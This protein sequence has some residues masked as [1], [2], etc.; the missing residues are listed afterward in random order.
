M[1]NGLLKKMAMMLAKVPK[2]DLEKNIEVAKNILS[3]SNKDDLNKFINSKE[4]ENLL[5]KEKKQISEALKNNEI[6]PE[7]IDTLSE[8]LNNKN[9]EL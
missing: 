3:N 9:A 2:K 8:I 1:D 7:N 6:K 4:I 5:G